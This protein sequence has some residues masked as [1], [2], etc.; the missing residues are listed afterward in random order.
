M[1]KS[2]GNVVTIQEALKKF[3][4]ADVIRFHF[5]KHHY[6]EAFEFSPT[7][8]QASKEEFRTIESTAKAAPRK[9]LGN[10]EAHH[11]EGS[12]EKLYRLFSEAMD[13]DLDT[14]AAVSLLLEV[15]KKVSEAVDEN[16]KSE[17]ALLFWEMAETL[18]FR[19]V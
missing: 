1:S 3:A 14:P 4:N 15:A 12:S 11:H 5:L 13:D 19:L 7:D 16:S 9:G 18:G 10:I 6:R 17:S 2:L 8:L